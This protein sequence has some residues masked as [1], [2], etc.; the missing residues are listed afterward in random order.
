[1]NTSLAGDKLRLRYE[2][3]I[4]LL[5]FPTY[6]CNEFLSEEEKYSRKDGNIHLVYGGIIAPSDKPKE[7]FG[8]NQ[9]IALAKK[10]INQGLCFHMYLSPHFSP[11]QIK[12]L[13]QDYIQLAAKTRN[14]TFKQWMPQDKAIKEFSKCDFATMVSFFDGMKLNKFHWDTAI[15]SKFFTYLS[16]GLPVI[17][18]EE[19]GN[20]S[21]LVRKYGCGIVVNQKD[22]DNLFDIIK[23]CDYEELKTNVKRAR[24][25]LS[26][27]KHIGR[28][29]EF[30]DQVY[31]TKSLKHEAR[32]PEVL[33]T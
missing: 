32:Q 15:P 9:F 17:V 23:Q 29:I 4:P 7:L 10:L 12:K 30:Y 18:S 22:F 33:T 6:V 26:M 2:S 14:F 3:A 25:D 8:D 28:L 5:E 11:F 21:A 24:E 20:I 13:Y 31:A 27:E 19:H 16:S 1:M